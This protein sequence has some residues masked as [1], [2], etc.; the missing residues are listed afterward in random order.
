MPATYRL[1]RDARVPEPRGAVLFA[2]VHIWVKKRR[3]DRWA[4]ERGIERNTQFGKKN[5]VWPKPRSIHHFFDNEMA[6]A[7]CRSGTNTKSFGG[8]VHMRDA[9]S[10]LHV[11]M[12]AVDDA[13]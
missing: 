3:E 7:A 1:V 10:R 4:L 5:Q 6:A 13:G 8:L 2:A 12:T 11:D 9:K